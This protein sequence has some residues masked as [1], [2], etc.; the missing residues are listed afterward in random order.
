MKMTVIKTLTKIIILSSF[1]FIKVSQINVALLF[2]RVL[3]S[4]LLQY[5]QV[6]F[7]N[8]PESRRKV[9]KA[10]ANDVSTERGSNPGPLE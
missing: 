3:H 9:G 4:L 10:P 6:P 2:R 5:C 7:I 1:F 8:T